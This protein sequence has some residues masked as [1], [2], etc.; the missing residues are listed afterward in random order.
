[1]I[2]TI[3]DD[4]SEQILYDDPAIPLLVRRSALSRFPDFQ[5][6]SH[7]HEELELFYATQGNATVQI[8]SK[9]VYI[10]EGNALFINSKQPHSVFSTDGT[11]CR[12]FCILFH[13]KLLSI[14]PEIEE[15]FV[16]PTLNDPVFAYVLLRKE[17]CSEMLNLLCRID[18]LWYQYRQGRSFI[19]LSMLYA[20]WSEFLEMTGEEQH[21]PL[22]ENVRIQRAMLNFIHLNYPQRI[23]LDQIAA[24]GGVCK[25]KC[26]Q[27]FKKYMGRSPNEYL[28]AYR[29]EKAAEMLRGTDT[30]ITEISYACGFCGPS[31]FSS[32]FLKRKGCSP[33]EYRNPPQ[34]V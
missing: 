1:M 4:G 23:T 12:F 30:P 26:C 10:K 18:S 21:I 8:G 5:I 11:D 19:A 27:L 29:M 31:Y 22:D 32:Q 2:F 24:S 14:S 13:P 7:W 25:S 34:T 3:L 9:K 16:R 28:N 33:S 15:R 20:F 17:Y 6:R